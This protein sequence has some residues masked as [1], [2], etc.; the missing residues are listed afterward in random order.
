MIPLSATI[1]NHL[2]QSTQFAVVAWLLNLALKKNRANI[3]Y[4]IWFAAS[5]KFLIPFSLLVSAGSYL[6]LSSAP[7]IVQWNFHEIESFSR[8]FGTPAS[9]PAAQPTPAALT[10][11][12]PRVV[13][14]FLM[15][16]WFAGFTAVA[17]S[18]YLRRRRFRALLEKAQFLNDGREVEALRRVQ[19]RRGC[20]APIYIALS[21]SAL[22]PGVCG[23]FTHLLL[24][25]TDI[26]GRLDDAQLEAVLAHEVAHIERR[27]NLLVTVHM[28]VE[29]LFWFHPLVWWVGSRMVEERERACD[30]EVLKSGSDSEAYAGAILKVCQYYLQSPLTTVSGISGSNLRTRIEDIM[31]NRTGV[32]LSL[33]KKVLL[34]T[35]AAILVAVPILA[36]VVHPTE[37]AP[38][39]SGTRV[40]FE[41]ASVTVNKATDTREIALQYLPS[42]RVVARGTPLFILIQQAYDGERIAPSAEFQKLDGNIIQRRY[43]VEGVAAESAIPSGASS[44][45]RNERLRQ[46]LQTLLADRFKLKVHREAKSQPVYALVVAKNGPKMQPSALQEKECGTRVSDLFDASSCHSFMGGQ[47]QGLHGVAVTMSDLAGFLIRFA[48]KPVINKTGLTGLYNIQTVGWRPLLPRPP[49][50]DGGTESQRAEDLAFADPSRPTLNDILDQLGLKLETL[51]ASVDTLFLDYIEAPSEN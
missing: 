35:A 39:T 3:R 29:M 32:Q 47:G 30:E 2:W 49:R 19:S 1:G 17:L 18:R 11:V 9:S 10:P 27:D 28:M 45:I 22:E 6:H 31:V 16:P 46:M 42:G 51:T 43:D 13:V 4:W 36:G 14:W 7:E 38:Q 26:S 23:M 40:A 50:P 24:L 21:S 5:L 44:E 20:R 12:R 41:V 48:D 34:V 8:P 25:P 33:A 37:A 15:A